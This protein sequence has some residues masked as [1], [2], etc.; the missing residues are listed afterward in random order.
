M[1]LYS[2]VTYLHFIS[3]F[4]LLSAL[5]VELSIIKR[6]MTKS[7]FVILKKAD[8]FFGVF[9]FLT[10]V[11]GFLRMCYFGKGEDYYL[12]N[13]IFV[14]KF[15]LFILAG[16]LSIYPTIQFLKLG[17]LKLEFIEFEHFKI[18]LFSLRIELILLLVIPLL[19]VL[20]AKGIGM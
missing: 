5:I 6:K 13:P 17:K 19:A 8:L 16:L 7:N 3:I 9:A 11:T 2:M 4:I 20:V 18:I 14:M 12:S 15:S 10:A 1:W